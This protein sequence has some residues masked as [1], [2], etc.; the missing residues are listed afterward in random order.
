MHMFLSNRQWDISK[1]LSLKGLQ[2]KVF[3]KNF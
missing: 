1:F 3:K 2:T